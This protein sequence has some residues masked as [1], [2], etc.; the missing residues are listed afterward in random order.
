M[1]K[2]LTLE[3]WAKRYQPPPSIKTVRRWRASGN[4]I[5]QPTKSGRRYYVSENARYIDFSDPD[6]I[7]QAAEALSEPAQEKHG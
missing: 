5:P 7:A 2:L 1:T 3:E 4:I 6:Y